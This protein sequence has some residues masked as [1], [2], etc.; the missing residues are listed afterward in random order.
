MI[1]KVIFFVLAFAISIIILGK[2][3]KRKDRIYIFILIFEFIGI[4]IRFIMINNSASQ[5]LVAKM[6]A[7]SFCTIIPIFIII[8]ERKNIYLSEILGIF[9]SNLSLKQSNND[10]AR[11][12]LIKLITKYP[13]SYYAHRLLAKIYEKDGK[14]EDAIDEY[15]KVVEINPKDYD[16]YFQIAF[17]LNKIDKKDE[18]EKMLISLISK[19]PEYYKASELL[20]TILYDKEKFREAAT[21]YLKALEY[22]PTRYELYYSLGMVYTRLNDFQTA[23]EYYEKAATL[24]SMLYHAKLNIAQIALITGD[25]EESEERF[26]ECVQ[27]KDSES[28]AYYYLAVIALLNGDKQR[29]INYINVAIQMDNNIYKLVYKHE[30]FSDIR[31]DIKVSETKMHS[32]HY[33]RQE[34]KTREHLDETIILIDKMKKNNTRFSVN[35]SKN[36]EKNEK[37]R[38]EY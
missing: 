38:E 6:I 28:Y 26:L 25:L 22:N 14:D 29:A 33:T 27:D 35:E 19:K 9:S 36:I 32:Y 37:Q 4:F 16:S 1:E 30:I 24:N 17:L 23:K 34:N 2:L 3:I 31:K 8:L 5:N 13:N 21:V 10:A 20:G 15:V 7:Y 11:R 18:S 12:K